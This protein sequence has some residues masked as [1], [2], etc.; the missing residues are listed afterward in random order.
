MLTARPQTGAVTELCS[1][2]E[3]PRAKRHRWRELAEAAPFIGPTALGL[4]VFFLGPVVAAFVLGFTEWNVFTPPQWVGFASFSQL[5]NE[6]MFSQI[7]T[8]TVVFI[9]VTVPLST[10][11][12]FFAALMFLRETR[13]SRFYRVL[14]FMPVV[15]SAVSVGLIWMALMQPQFGVINYLLK[16][17]GLGQPGWLASTSW[18]LPAIIIVSIWRNIGYN[19]IIYIGGLKGVSSE[20][21]EAGELD[22]AGYWRRVRYLI[23]P[24]TSPTTFFAVIVGLISS[25]QVFDLTYIMTSGGPGYSTNTL[26]FYI[27]QQ[28]FQ[29]FSFGTASAA[30]DI[31]F[32]LTAA[33]VGIGFVLQKRL[34]FYG[35]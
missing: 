4:F 25:F 11:L 8:N 16:S 3:L 9:A 20:L 23:L 30:G 13:L 22:G 7:V 24:L 2:P 29:D 10:V 21:L 27:Y 14:V 31:L 18:A 32:L 33:I 15:P 1:P 28:G 17:V 19:M 12:G 5:F 26:P 35:D 6:P 34:V